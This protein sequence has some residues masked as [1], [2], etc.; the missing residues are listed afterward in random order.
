M[1][2][3]IDATSLNRR[4]ARV[5]IFVRHMG[6]CFRCPSLPT[7]VA[8]VG[9]F[10]AGT[11]FEGAF[12]QPRINSDDGP[13]LRTLYA[14]SQ[15]IEEGKRIVESSCT[16][17]H[18]ANGI[19]ESP[20]VPHLAG[21]RPAYLYLELR[22]YQAGVRGENAMNNVVRPLSDDALFKAAA[23]FASLDP[24]QTNAANG[25]KAAAPDPVQAGKTAAAGCAGCHGDGGISKTPGMPSLVGLDPKYLVAAMKAYKSGQRKNDMMKS[26]LASVTDASMNNI[27]LYYA[28]Q[29]P[30]RA[31]TPAAGDRVAGGT[32]GAACAGCHGTDGVSGNPATPSLAGQ[33]AAYLGSA[34]QA[35]KQGTRS[36]ETM[37]GLAASLDDGAVRNLAAF[38]A[39]QEPKPPNVRQPLTAEEWAQRCD[40][41][42]GVNGNSSDPRLPALAAQRLDYLEKV[43]QDYRTGARKSPQMAAMS[44]VL[45]DQDITNVAAHYA[46][47]KARGV[48]FVVLPSKP[49]TK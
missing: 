30:E 23:Y 36:D 35:Y 3:S 26:M 45:T 21:Q 22:A 31:Q 39:S 24:P 11:C 1:Q 33:D 10:F 16:G 9:V 15:D 34:L 13:E 2:G 6:A 49:G 7:L 43:L 12:A 46:R 5:R 28:L 19:S 32:A 47:Q 40:R 20:G 27:A 41:C 18:G 8:I 48:V 14:N 44:N 4:E 38:Y 25:A 29:K 42:H 17:C 37:K